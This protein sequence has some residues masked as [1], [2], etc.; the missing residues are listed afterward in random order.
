MKVL[1]F[2]GETFG[3]LT[4]SLLGTHFGCEGQSQAGSKGKSRPEW[5]LTR[6]IYIITFS[7]EGVVKSMTFPWIGP[8]I[9]DTVHSRYTRNKMKRNLTNL[10]ETHDPHTVAVARLN[11]MGGRWSSSGLVQ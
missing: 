10:S 7:H 11:L 6:I 5:P 1:G 2:L 3:F 9:Y 4:A 8:E